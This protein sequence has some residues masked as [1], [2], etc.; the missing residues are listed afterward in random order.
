MLIQIGTLGSH[1]LVIADH[2]GAFQPNVQAQIDYT[3]PGA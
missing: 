3:Q 1:T 2:N